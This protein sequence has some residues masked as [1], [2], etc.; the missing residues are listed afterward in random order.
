MSY[1]ALAW[2]RSIKTGSFA[3]KAILMAIANYADENG[4]CFPSQAQLADDTELSK[5]TIVRS[6]EIL[7]EAGLLSRSR[8]HRSDG[9]RTS[10]LII[11]ILSATQPRDTEPRDSLPRDTQSKPKCHSGTAEP[12][13]EPSVCGVD[14][15]ARERVSRGTRISPDWKPRPAEIE[16]ALSWGWTPAEVDD[17]AER[18]RDYWLSRT[19]QGATKLNW[20]LTFRN[21]LKEINDR[22]PKASRHRASTA[23]KLS[24]AFDDLRATVSRSSR[25][26]AG[27]GDD[28]EPRGMVHVPDF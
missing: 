16:L 25:G 15:P 1:Q 21:R 28:A 2:A 26:G 13:T 20:H 12:I 27:S 10:D 7:E 6:M 5:R 9:T 18:F 14:A 11:L 3:T 19:G 23:D 22:R 8:R 24:S 4:T 17:Q